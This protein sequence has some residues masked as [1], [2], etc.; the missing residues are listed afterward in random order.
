[1]LCAGF[2]SLTAQTPRAQNHHRSLMPPPSALSLPRPAVLRSVASLSLGWWVLR[3]SSARTRRFWDSGLLTPPRG[4]PC[5]TDCTEQMGR[6]GC[7]HCPGAPSPWPWWPTP[8]WHRGDFGG[9]CGEKE[10]HVWGG[11][12]RRHRAG[13]PRRSL[14]GVQSW[15]RRPV[16]T[17]SSVAWVLRPGVVWGRPPS[18]PLSSGNNQPHPPPD[19]WWEARARASAAGAG[20][21]PPDLSLPECPAGTG[22]RLLA[23]HP[24][25]DEHPTPGW[26]RGLDRREAKPKIAR[27]GR[28]MEAVPGR[29]A[30]AGD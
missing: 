23:R 11:V 8:G 19:V 13:S 18:F 17:S 10:G 12:G 1:M 16:G 21:S 27:D 29:A 9:V 15:E 2:A 24:S 30:G 14:V 4:T 26:E 20:S 6:S 7:Q 3:G 5:F 25:R 28:M 22:P